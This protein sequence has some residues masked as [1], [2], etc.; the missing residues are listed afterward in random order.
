MTTP[1]SAAR[2]RSLVDVYGGDIRARAEALRAQYPGC[3][4]DFVVCTL[5]YDLGLRAE[6]IRRALRADSTGEAAG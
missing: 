1:P 5:E 4:D 2:H 6:T 3:G